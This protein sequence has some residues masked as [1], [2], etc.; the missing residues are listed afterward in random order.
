MDD[1]IRRPSFVDYWLEDLREEFGNRGI[2]A[3]VPVW[4]ILFGA[5]SAIAAYFLPEEFWTSERWDVSTAVY[6]VIC[7][8]NGLFLALSWNAFGRIHDSISSAGFSGWLRSKQMLHKYF[9]IVDFIH[10]WQIVAVALSAIALVAV[11]YPFVPV[12]GQRIAFAAAIAAT[13]YALRWA[14]GAVKVMHDI[15]WYRSIYDEHQAAAGDG[16]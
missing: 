15:T 14:L 7:T 1:P 8:L 11:L 10:I 13:G 3:F 6:G 16:E 9:F 12:W 2:R 5:S 4:L